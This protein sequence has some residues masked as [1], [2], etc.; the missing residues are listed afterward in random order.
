MGLVSVQQLKPWKTSRLQFESKSRNK[1]TKKSQNENNGPCAR[2]VQEA[3]PLI[4]AKVTFYVLF[5]LFQL[6]G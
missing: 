5:S 6:I 4:Q 1:K 2:P 3:F